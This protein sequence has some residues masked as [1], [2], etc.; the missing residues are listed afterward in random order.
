MAE[1]PITGLYTGL[2]IILAFILSAGI[3]TY[4]GK[5]KISI[6][7]GGDISLRGS[8]EF[9][10]QRR[11]LDVDTDGDGVADQRRDLIRP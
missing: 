4:R 8:V 6:G 10:L 5:T 7:D 9:A 11:T 2:T 1:L 3:G